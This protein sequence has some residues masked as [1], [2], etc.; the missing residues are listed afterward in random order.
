MHG[1]SSTG[2]AGRDPKV[3]E[4][5]A[6]KGSKPIRRAARVDVGWRGRRDSN[7]RGSA[8]FRH[9]LSRELSAVQGS[10]NREASRSAEPA[11]VLRSLGLP[12]FL[13]SSVWQR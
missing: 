11:S 12:T 10:S 3:A 4:N 1:R 7:P 13:R 2:T 6:E 5:T 8:G 9:E